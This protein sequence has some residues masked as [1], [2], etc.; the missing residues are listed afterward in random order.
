MST[1]TTA[2][3]KTLACGDVKGQFKS[4]FKRVNAVNSKNGPFEMIFCV[5]DF[6]GRQLD[7]ENEQFWN[8]IKS[9]KV[10]CPVPIYLL[11]PVEES[12]KA[13]FPDI[14]GC[15]LAPD[16]LYLGRIGILTTSQGLKLAYAS[17]NVDF[18]AVKAL[19][20]RSQCDLGDFQGVD[21]LISSDWPLGLGSGDDQVKK[22]DGVSLISRLAV[23]LRPR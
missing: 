20:I 17:A 4:F 11:G 2:P 14:E 7:D 8:D 3:L 5:G 15:E 12:Q 19:E 6:F 1:M 13:F 22:T 21:I 10:K 16:V 9:G 18:E 23:Q